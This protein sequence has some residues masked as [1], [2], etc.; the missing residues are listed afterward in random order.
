[1][2]TV[3]GSP[4]ASVVPAAVRAMLFGFAVNGST[5]ESAEPESS[6]ADSESVPTGS[7]VTVSGVDSVVAAPVVPPLLGAL[8]V[9]EEQ[10][11]RRMT[12]NASAPA[13]ATRVRPGVLT[14]EEMRTRR[15]LSMGE[16]C[17][18]QSNRG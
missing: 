1:M 11:A 15:V 8:E 13:A 17:A 10:A 18:I 4:R 3:A 7:S 2:G 9:D 14:N 12:A 5:S 16:L 6:G